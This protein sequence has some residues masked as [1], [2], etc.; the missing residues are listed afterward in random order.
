[1]GETSKLI[2]VSG[3]SGAGKSTVVEALVADPRFRRAVT[4]TTRPPRPGER[5]GVDYEFLEHARVYG[6]RYGTLRR[7]V[8][9][10]MDEGRHCVL[11]VDVQGV[12]NL[13]RIAMPASYVFVEPPSL[14]V[15]ERRLRARG[16][17]PE[18][19][20]RIRLRTAEREM[21][22]RN[23][24]DL[25][26]VNDDAKRAAAEI[27]DWVLRRTAAASPEERPGPEGRS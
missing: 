10:V 5:P 19:A 6:H 3:P 15:L 26:V 11:V 23:G 20:L 2:V 16:T 17:E 21:G 7:N 22:A 4:A 18:E 27:R 8:Q 1:M 13:R 24:F 12:A 9:A 14:E 25:R